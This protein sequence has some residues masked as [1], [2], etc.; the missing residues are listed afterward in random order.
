M[1]DDRV[2]Y[3]IRSGQPNIERYEKKLRP[4]GPFQELENLVT[5]MPGML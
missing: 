5:K 2:A 1:K 3:K 4:L